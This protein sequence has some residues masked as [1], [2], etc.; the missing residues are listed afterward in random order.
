MNISSHKSVLAAGVAA[1]LALSA[2]GGGGGHSDSTGTVTAPGTVSTTLTGTA[3]VGAPIVGSVFAIDS[4]G[5]VSPTATTNAQGAFTI[6]VAGMTAPFILNVTGSAGGKQVVLN[7]IA[8]APGQTVNI[9]PLTDLIVATASGQPAGTALASLCA[10][11]AGKA[12]EACTTVLSN[13][14]S[15]QKLDTAVAAVTEMIKPINASST[16]PLTGAFVANGTG[17]DAVLDQIQVTPADAQGA[18]ATVTLVATN[19]TLGSVTLP[20]NAG[21]TATIPASTAPGAEDLAKANA[22]AT[23]LPEIR[24]CMASLS[25]LYPKTNFVAP[26]RAAVLPFIDSSFNMGTGMGRDQIVTALTSTDDAARPGLTLEA[27]GLAPV[28]MQPL[29]ATELATLTSTSNTSTTRVADFV[30]ARQG[31]GDTA[32]TF[33]NGKPSSAWVQIRTGNDAGL[34]TWKLVKT[35]DTSVC[36][37]GWKLAGNGHLDMHMNARI[38][39]NIDSKGVA[40][41]TRLWAFHLEQSSLAAEN[42]DGADVRGPGLTTYG[43]FKTNASA[44]VR[45]RLAA[46]AKGY[47]S[48]RIADSTGTPSAYYGNGEALQSCQDIAAIAPAPAGLNENTMCI[49]ETKTAAGKIY[50]WT[51]RSGSTPVSAFPFQTNAVPLSLAFAQ[52]NQASLFPTI[53]SVTPAKL[54]SIQANTLLDNVVTFN[55]TQSAAYDA[56]MDNCGLA[57]FEAS[58]AILLNAEQNAVSMETACTFSTKGLNSLVTNVP[59]T[60]VPGTSLFKFTGT[61]TSGYI[62]VTAIVLGNQATSTQAYPN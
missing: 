38:Q 20:A 55:Y 47:Y 51:L 30:K 8:T 56:K 16:N 14:T 23:V 7:S 34:L 4:K 29:N 6:D 12:P 13:A 33:T 40:S 11:V 58:G 31:A 9:T 19:N 54:S 53:T 61:A 36:P 15:A 18:V 24:A 17:M 49:D 57:L 43:N 52:A 62:N 39:R 42:A 3:A 25:A 10:P 2:C 45:L 5:A 44:S 59:N 46:P 28:D 26:S 37:G 41:F 21:G 50:V 35:S 22:A 48:L 32:I 1:M 27:V 60:D